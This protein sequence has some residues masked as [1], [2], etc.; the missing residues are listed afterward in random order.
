MADARSLSRFHAAA[1]MVAATAWSPA[2]AQ[3]LDEYK[4]AMEIMVSSA[5]ICSDYL[6]R[7]EVLED[8]RARARQHLG[9]AGMPTGEMATFIAGI[10][11]QA[12]AETSNETQKQVACEIINIPAIK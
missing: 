2:S 12:M 4:D 6:K 9:D 5:T 7:P 8:M 1:L 10:E 11:K 3:T